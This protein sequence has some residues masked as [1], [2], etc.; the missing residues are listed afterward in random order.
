MLAFVIDADNLCAAASV[1]EAFRL[2]EAEVGP[3]GWRRAYGSAENLRHLS[4]VLKLHLVRP[5]L[6]MSLSKNTTDV[7]LA[8]DVMELSYQS[9]CPATIAIGS[10]DADFVPLVVRLRE[11]GIRV[12]CVSERGKMA[13][14]AVDAYDDV[15]FVGE[16]ASPDAALDDSATSTPA[17]APKAAVKKASVKAA[18][19]KKAATK[20]VP[21][22]KTAPV[23]ST[24]A[25]GQ[26]KVQQILSAVPSLKAGNEHS[27]GEVVKAL[28]DHKLL[29]KTGSSTKLFSKF[30]HHF[31][32]MPSKQPNRVRYILPPT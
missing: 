23:K 4:D 21:A 6:N 1:E 14:E 13:A 3:V 30:P 10:G 27:L 20:K 9:P 26:V 29:S 5:F 11:R 25:S 28:H 2:L 15:M 12:I 19:A 16:D 32:L 24:A 31:E 8:V 22:K 18:P 17:P 7:A